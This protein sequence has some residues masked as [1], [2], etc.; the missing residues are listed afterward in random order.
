MSD[1]VWSARHESK[2]N[3]VGQLKKITLNTN[4]TGKYQHNDAIKFIKKLKQVAKENS[5]SWT[6]PTA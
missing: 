5:T 1:A 6:R 4:D 3:T 2:I